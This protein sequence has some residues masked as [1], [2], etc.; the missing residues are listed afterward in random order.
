MSTIRATLICCIVLCQ[1]GYSQQDSQQTKKPPQTKKVSVATL[2]ERPLFNLH[3]SAA[4]SLVPLDDLNDHISVIT[5]NYGLPKSAALKNYYFIGGGVSLHADEYN[6]VRIA[7]GVALNKQRDSASANSLMLHTISLTYLFHVPLNNL[8]VYAGA[9]VGMLGLRSET[10][11]KRWNGVLAVTERM[12]DAAAVAGAEYLL[13]GG[14]SVGA[15]VRYHYATTIRSDESRTDFT[16]TGV[17]SGLIL[18][19]PLF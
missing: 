1:F 11:Y 19:I 16:L 15:E 18:T 3:L 12:V 10:T 17:Q 5:K 7:G 9:G 8:S 4:L 2:A 6:E 13:P 14:M